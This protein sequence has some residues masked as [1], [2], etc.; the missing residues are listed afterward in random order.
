[1]FLWLLDFVI[2][3]NNFVPS[4]SILVYNNTII[5][6]RLIVYYLI[7]ANSG[8]CP[9]FA[10][11]Q[12]IYDSHSRD[13]CKLSYKS[14]WHYETIHHKQYTYTS[15][16]SRLMHSVTEQFCYSRYSSGFSSL[17]LRVDIRMTQGLLIWKKKCT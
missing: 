9:S 8:L 13:N 1:M 5:S 12:T 17:C 2:P 10:I 16:D 3:S 11:Y 14:M 4:F 7:I 6:L 15:K